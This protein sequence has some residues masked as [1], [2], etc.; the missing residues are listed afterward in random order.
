[1][2]IP[3]E[4]MKAEFKRVLTALSVS[5]EKA[6]ICSRLFAENSL[7]GVS[8]HGLNRFSAFVKNI[9]QGI[10]DKNA[11]P[12]IVSASKSIEH[13][14]GRYGIG[15]YN[16]TL[17]M[18]K[19][20]TIA[21]QNGLGLVTVKYTN[22]WMRAGSYG[23][24]A[25]NEHCIG[26]C[27]TNTI[28][29]MPPWGGRDPK[30]GNNPLVIA[31]PRPSGRHVV[32]DMALS[33]YSYGQLQEHQLHSRKLEVP[34]GYDDEGRLTQDPASI[35]RSQ[36]A[37][38][39]GFWKGSGLSLIIDVLLSSLT[40]G[41]SVKQITEEGVESGISQLFLCIHQPELHDHLCDEIIDFMK[42]STPVSSTG[43]VAYPG[44]NSLRRREENLLHGIPVNE[45]FWN[46]VLSM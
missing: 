15:M 19:A 21:R 38:P 35:L 25:A 28:A 8:S 32:L 11:E 2:R 3:F 43:A 46:E 33:Q 39:A 18:S 20:I 6:E 5:E 24:Q 40:G 10:I 36:R 14:N 37:L 1:M 42:T 12:E 27:T 29:N 13:W 41:R 34:G 7:D 17:A 30:L 31:V 44:E 23:W 26:I 45:N 9:K 22:H 4:K 16:A